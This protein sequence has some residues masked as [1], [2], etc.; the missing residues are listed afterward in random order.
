MSDRITVTSGIPP[1]PG[2]KKRP[3]GPRS[4]S[5]LGSASA[6]Q[7]D[8]MR[9]AFE[10]WHHC[11]EVVRFLFWPAYVL[12]HPDH[13]KCVL[14][15]NHCNYNKNFPNMKA[16]RDLFGN[17]L[18]T[19]DR[20][21][22]LHQ[23]R[24]MQPSFHRQWLAGFGRLMTEATVTMLEHWQHA[25][26]GDALLDISLKM[27]LLSLRIVGLT[28]AGRTEQP[29]QGDLLHH[30]GAGWG[31]LTLSADRRCLSSLSATTVHT[32]LLLFQGRRGHLI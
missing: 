21:S 31:S 1:V 32:A 29:Q 15:E 12:C 22:W 10:M 16:A 4:L 6:L 13:V 25:A 24:L 30:R 3:P 11:G 23:R 8:P 9:F 28:L 19:S 2:A 20:E 5:L 18:F 27:M 14:Q 26:P 17:G 7:R